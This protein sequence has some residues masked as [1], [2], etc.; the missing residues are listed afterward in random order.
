MGMACWVTVLQGHRVGL[1]PFY[2]L[3]NHCRYL[4]VA[5][6]WCLRAISLLPYC[7]VLE[8]TFEAVWHLTGCTKALT[9]FFVSLDLIQKGCGLCVVEVLGTL[10]VGICQCEMPRPSVHGRG[11][12]SILE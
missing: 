6:P 1:G 2:F 3:W 12:S 4:S 10:T 11:E 5:V 9:S 8:Q 7:G